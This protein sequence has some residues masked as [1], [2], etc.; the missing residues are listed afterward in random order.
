M[1]TERKP[2]SYAAACD[3]C[4]AVLELDAPD[5]DVARAELVTRGWVG[6]AQRGK[7]RERWHWWC[8]RCAPKPSPSFGRSTGDMR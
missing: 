8:P 3:K 4:G 6:A 2:G 1:L 5:V 7:H